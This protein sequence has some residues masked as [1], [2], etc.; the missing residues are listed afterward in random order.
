MH[1]KEF[2]NVGGLPAPA[3]YRYLCARICDWGEVWS[4]RNAEGW[5]LSRD[6]G[7][8][9]G[10]PVWPHPRFAEACAEGDWRDCIPAVISLDDWLNK[11]LPGMGRDT[12]FVAAFLLPGAPNR[13]IP[14]E[15]AEHRRHLLEE[16]ES[17]GELAGD[18]DEATRN[19]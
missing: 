18:E 5:V 11:W 17:F 4:L 15:P 1:D 7:G 19:A 3:R 10:V 6:D 2:A 14:V 13:G 12:R 8:H 16:L 9:E